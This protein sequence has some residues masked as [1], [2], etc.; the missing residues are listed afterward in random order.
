MQI[1]NTNMSKIKIKRVTNKETISVFKDLLTGG[2]VNDDVVEIT[3]PNYEELKDKVNKYCILLRIL[4]DF[5]YLQA[6]FNSSSH[7]LHQL[8]ITY[9]EMFRREFDPPSGLIVTGT[10]VAKTFNVFYRALK[11]CKLID[12]I[13]YTCDNLALLKNSLSDINK[14]NDRFLLKSNPIL[15]FNEL[16]SCDFKDFYA[17]A[18][19]YDRGVLLQLL[20]KIFTY[21]Y[22]IVRIIMRP[23]IDIADFINATEM[24]LD[25]IQKQLPHCK[26][27][28]NKIKNSL[29]MLHTNFEGYYK[30]FYVTNNPSVILEGFISDVASSN[31][32]SGVQSAVISGQFKKIIMFYKTAYKKQIAT[33]SKIG[34]L[35]NIVDD[36]L[37]QLEKTLAEAE[38][39]ELEPK[40]QSQ[41]E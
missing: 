3:F 16:P 28:L 7:D 33:N 4:S 25:D 24:V 36:R 34:N 17:L 27:A 1:Y 12:S 23:D 29:S 39:I 5:P 41:S 21:S 10:E 26:Q 2:G 8:H 32:K 30:E 18:N 19:E 37:M 6:T 38:T 13:I 40:E 22:D 15:P 11:Q 9:Q 20:H 14:L 35:I 31:N